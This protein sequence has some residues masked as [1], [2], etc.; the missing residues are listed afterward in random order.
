MLFLR[1][2]KKYWDLS[3]F[4]SNNRVDKKQITCDKIDDYQSIIIF[5]FK[6]IFNNLFY[7]DEEKKK[8]FW[9]CE[10]RMNLRYIIRKY[11]FFLSR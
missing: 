9:I 4:S 2:S 5:F 6:W 10:R 1:I 11:I 3:W 7:G 8:R